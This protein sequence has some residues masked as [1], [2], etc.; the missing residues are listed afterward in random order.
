MP[1]D[2]FQ[3]FNNAVRF[4]TDRHEGQF[5]KG[6]TRPY[7]IHPLTVAAILL[8]AGKGYT[9]ATAGVLHDT[10]ED[11]KTTHNQLVQLFG[12]QIA[13]LVKEVTD[14]NK[15]RVLNTILIKSLPAIWIKAADVIS[16]VT[17]IYMDYQE[18]GDEVFTR[19]SGGKEK[20]IEHYMTLMERCQ[21]MIDYDDDVLFHKLTI[22]IAMLKLL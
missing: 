17:D 21:S 3:Q 8:D 1:T 4:A 5:R 9:V 6:T 18:V 16:N 14:T 22:C 19:F 2:Y 7:I 13:G 10:V 20:T 11:T 15:D 12:E